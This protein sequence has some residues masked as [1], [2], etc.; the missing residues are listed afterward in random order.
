[1]RKAQHGFTPRLK[2]S[3]VYDLKMHSF[4]NNS[5]FFIYNGK[6]SV[7]T[8]NSAEISKIQINKSVRSSVISCVYSTRPRFTAKDYRRT[9]E[10]D[11]DSSSGGYC[12]KTIQEKYKI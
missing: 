12:V 10:E 4:H 7:G 3:F 11:K 5:G 9:G 2:G 6:S 1:M 8:K